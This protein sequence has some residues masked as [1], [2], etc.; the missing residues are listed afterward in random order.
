MNEQ[1]KNRASG[2]LIGLAVGDALGVHTEGKTPEQIQ[3][4]YGFVSDFLSENPSGSDDTEFACFNA[5][6][7]LE[8]GKNINADIIAGQWRKHVVPHKGAYKGAGFSEMMAIENL[9][10]GMNPPLSGKHA[11]S[12]SDGLAMRCAPFGI[13]NPGNPEDACRLTM[14]DGSVTHSEEGIYSGMAAAAAIAMAMTDASTDI[15]F[16]SALDAI[17]VDSWTYRNIKTALDIGS[18]SSGMNNALMKLYDSLVCKYYHWADLGPEAVGLSFGIIAASGGDF[19]KAVLGGVNVGR[20]TDTIAAICGAI[21]GA[22]AGYEKIPS[23]WRDKIKT[24]N[25]RC[26]D[27]ISNIDIAGLADDLTKLIV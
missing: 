4:E 9:K 3:K 22:K 23:K 15:I 21:L 12:W 1:I 25:G 17:P 27:S 2:C 20:D 16:K 10:K 19:E 26:I 14:E 24:I 8:H 5:K 18:K 11:H 7:L 6:I 13:V